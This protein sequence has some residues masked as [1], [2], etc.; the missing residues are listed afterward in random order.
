MI[1]EAADGSI[2]DVP[3]WALVDGEVPVL[4]SLAEYTAEYGTVG[5]N[6]WL[7]AQGG[8]TPRPGVDPMVAAAERV[9]ERYEALDTGQFSD[10]YYAR[11][12]RI[13]ESYAAGVTPYLGS[14][15]DGTLADPIPRQAGEPS[16]S[17]ELAYQQQF[18]PEPVIL[19]PPAPVIVPTVTPVA[20]PPSAPVEPVPVVTPTPVSTFTEEET[21]AQPG[22]PVFGTRGR[23]TPG[24]PAGFL[25][26]PIGIPNLSASPCAWAMARYPTAS[27]AAAAFGQ[28]KPGFGT[29]NNP[30]ANGGA[31]TAYLE[32][33]TWM[34]SMCRLG[35][36]TA[37]GDK[38][39]V[40]AVTQLQGAGG[41]VPVAPGPGG[42]PAGMPDGCI[43][44]GPVQPNAVM[45]RRC[46]PGMRLAKNDL[47][48]PEKMLPKAWWKNDP[49]PAKISHSEWSNFLKAGRTAKKL[50]T[51]AEKAEEFTGKKAI[52]SARSSAAKARAEVKLLEGS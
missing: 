5:N 27:A 2:L 8:Y 38:P 35:S 43:P 7:V 19:P 26:L 18:E 6:L 4:G 50:E 21:M 47:C 10:D 32:G 15:P 42:M 16:V 11:L 3:D 30:G 49:K 34:V 22:E 48:Y 51:I 13:R 44:A 31:Q 37:A 17:A 28:Q 52:K 39:V 40:G 23:Y 33:G 45:S 36:D 25:G 29:I 1:F 41:T 12:D 20:P 24:E 14:N 9:E 46:P